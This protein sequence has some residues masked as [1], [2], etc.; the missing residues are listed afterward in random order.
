MAHSIVIT[1][2]KGGTGKTTVS[3]NLAA[4]FAA[5]GLRVLLVDL[6]AQGHCAVG[7]GVR[8]GKDTPTVH[9]LFQNARTHLP[10]VVQDTPCPNLWL[11][12]ADTRFDTGG[13]YQGEGLLAREVQ[14]QAVSEAFDLVVIDTAPSQDFLLLNALNAAE[15]AIV[16]YVPHHLSLEGVKQLMRIIFSVKAGI[17]PGLKVFG[18]LPVMASEHINEHRSINGR[19]ASNFGAEGPLAAIRTDIKLAEAFGAG[20]PIRH[21]APRCRGAEDFANLS[22]DVASTLV[23]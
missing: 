13:W 5:L 7:L 12:P 4:E 20:K 15:V 19:L 6:D 21:Y 2:R 1:N 9:Q 8:T 11:A 16:P 10:D 17:N 3:V 23:G 22:R 18:Y 14:S